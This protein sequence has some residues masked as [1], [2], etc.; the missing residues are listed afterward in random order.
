[1]ASC[2]WSLNFNSTC[3][4]DMRTWIHHQMWCGPLVWRV[5]HNYYCRC[6][7]WSWIPFANVMQTLVLLTVAE[8]TV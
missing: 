2:F 1:V 3:K 7:M 6:D 8:F 4:W 5:K